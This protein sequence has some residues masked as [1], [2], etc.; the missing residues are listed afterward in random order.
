MERERKREIREEVV[1]DLRHRTALD[2]VDEIA[3]L[4]RIAFVRERQI[5]HL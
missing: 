1:Y 4:I 2:E 3:D 5:L